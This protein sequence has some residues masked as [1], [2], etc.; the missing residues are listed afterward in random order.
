[1]NQRIKTATS[2]GNAA[3]TSGLSS[4]GSM[5]VANTTTTAR[6][7]QEQFVNGYWK[8]GFSCR[9][10]LGSPDDTSFSFAHLFGNP[11]RLMRG[12]L[13]CVLPSRQHLPGTTPQPS[14]APMTRRFHDLPGRELDPSGRLDA[15]AHV[16]RL[17]TMV[18]ESAIPFPSDLH[19]QEA[20]ALGHLVRRLRRNRLVRHMARAIAVDLA[21]KRPRSSPND[22]EDL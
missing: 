15:P 6:P 9:P 17:S 20:I 12:C 18:A 7:F 5:P 11:F 2:A 10:I 4:G 8:Q 14:E 22:Q 1:T 13:V 19:E 16:A 21:S 3:R